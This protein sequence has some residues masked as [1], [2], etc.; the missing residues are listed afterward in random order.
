V[1]ELEADN[2]EALTGLAMVYSDRGDGKAAADLLAKVA[3][4]EPQHPYPDTALAGVRA[5]AGLQSAAE[6]LK[7]ASNWPRRR[8]PAA[9]SRGTMPAEKFDESLKEYASLVEEDPATCS[10][11]CGSRR[12]TGSSASMTRPRVGTTR[13]RNLDPTNPRSL[14]TR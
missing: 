7:R 8:H 6:T 3:E 13:R 2:D 10:R 1:L 9:R 14:I 11:S 12:S 4:K 5:D